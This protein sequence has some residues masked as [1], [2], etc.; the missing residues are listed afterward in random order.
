MNPALRRRNILADHSIFAVSA[1]SGSRTCH[2]GRKTQLN[3]ALRRR[4]ILADHSIFAVSAGNIWIMVLNYHYPTFTITTASPA[5]R[6]SHTCTYSTSTVPA[7]ELQQAIVS[8]S[9]VTPL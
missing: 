1:G 7:H 9:M 5:S 2:C 4:N 6:K 8:E 3:P